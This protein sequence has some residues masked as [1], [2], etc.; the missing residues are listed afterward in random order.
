MLFPSCT[1]IREDCY[2]EYAPPVRQYPGRRIHASPVNGL[3]A[4]EKTYGKNG[5]TNSDAVKVA[6][7]IFAFMLCSDLV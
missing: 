4:T 5:V 2:S 7:L 1:Y 3:P 6:M